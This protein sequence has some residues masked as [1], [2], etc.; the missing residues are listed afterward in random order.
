MSNSLLEAMA[1]A[2]PCIASRIAGNTDLIDDG[3]YGRLVERPEAASWSAAIL[4]LLGQPEMART[5]GAAARRR[6]DEEFALPIVVDR[7]V[8]LYRRM[9]AGS[10]PA[11]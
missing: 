3:R 8:D 9:M 1:T 7:Y 5:L 6:I 11:P 10:W 2:L 4:A